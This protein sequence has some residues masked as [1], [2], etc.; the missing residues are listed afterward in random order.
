MNPFYFI[1]FINDLV[2]FFTEITSNY[3]A[4]NNNL[5]SIGKDIVKDFGTATN[6]FHENFMVLNSKKYHF[7]CIGKT[8]KTFTFKDVCYE[9]S[10]EEAMLGINIDN[11]LFFDS[12]VKKCKKSGQKLNALLKISSFKQR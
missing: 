4:D 7:I 8:G 10:K 2:F 11:K 5:F 6:W 3:Y 1:F 9:I 12:H